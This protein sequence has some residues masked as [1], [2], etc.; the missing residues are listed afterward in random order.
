MCGDSA[1]SGFQSDSP[2][3]LTFIHSASRAVKICVVPAQN[4]SCSAIFGPLRGQIPM[5]TA[6]QQLQRPESWSIDAIISLKNINIT[7]GRMLADQKRQINAIRREHPELD[8]EILVSNLTVLHEINSEER[9]LLSLAPSAIRRA[10]VE[11]F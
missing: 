11:D 8:C 2:T 5:S 10:D 3:I 4:L 6:P 1:I 7:A 9:R